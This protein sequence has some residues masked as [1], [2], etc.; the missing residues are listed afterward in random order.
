MAE[1]NQSHLIEDFEAFEA[2]LPQQDYEQEESQLDN[3]THELLHW[4]YN[5]ETDRS[6]TSNGWPGQE[7]SLDV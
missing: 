3:P 2:N 5:L 1:P 4:R 6:A 7:F